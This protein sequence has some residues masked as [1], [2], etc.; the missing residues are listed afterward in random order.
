M[1]AE[2]FVQQESVILYSSAEVSKTDKLNRL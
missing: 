2:V 1:T